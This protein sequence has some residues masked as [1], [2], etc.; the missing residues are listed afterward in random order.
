MRL[1]ALKLLAARGKLARGARLDPR[2]LLLGRAA[3]RV[4]QAPRDPARGA[5]ALPHG[6]AH[7]RRGQPRGARRGAARLP[8]ARTARRQPA[9]RLLDR[10]GRPG[11]DADARLE[12]RLPRARLDAR[13]ARPGRGPLPPHRPAGRRQRLPICWPRAR[14]TRR[15]R[16]CWSASGRSSAPSPTDASRTRRA[17]ST[18]SCA[19]CAA[20]PI[21]TCAPWRSRAPP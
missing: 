2:L 10:G 13:Q 3:G 19:S 7:P 6:A 12:R 8:G 21:G 20:S 16:R 5:R 9:D 4:R 17:S 1:N 11:P 14:S 15:S 18:R